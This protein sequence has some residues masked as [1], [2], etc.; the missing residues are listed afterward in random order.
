MNDSLLYAIAFSQ[1]HGINLYERK[2]LVKLLLLSFIR[3]DFK[4][5]K[6]TFTKLK[7]VKKIID[8]IIDSRNINVSMGSHYIE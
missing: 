1:M 3:F 5:V 2:K 8:Q 7:N 4:C 6:A